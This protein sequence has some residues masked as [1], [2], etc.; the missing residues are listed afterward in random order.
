MRTARFTSGLRASD[1][2]TISQVVALDASGATAL[3]PEVA[4]VARAEG[5]DAHA[6]AVLARA[7]LARES[8]ASS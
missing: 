5:F 7:G 8:G 6:R 4:A 3:A 1:F 2:V